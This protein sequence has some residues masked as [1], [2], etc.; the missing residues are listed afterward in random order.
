MHLVLFDMMDTLV[1]EPYPL[2]LDRL[3]RSR[4]QKEFFFAS[5]SR[6]AAHAFERGE[7]SEGEFFKNFYN[8]DTPSEGLKKLPKPIKVKK[9]LFARMNYISGMAEILD[10][11]QAANTSANRHRFQLL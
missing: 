6:Q 5:K 11:L 3:F 8:P 9:S 7:L 1:R 10:M 4:E 2:A